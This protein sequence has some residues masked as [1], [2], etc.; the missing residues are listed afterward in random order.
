MLGN[1]YLVDFPH[2]GEGVPEEI[3]DR[4]IRLMGKEFTADM[5]ALRF[6]VVGCG[7]TGSPIAHLLARRGAGRILVVDRDRLDA[8]SCHRVHLTSV[9]DARTKAC[10]VAVIAREIR[11]IGLKTQVAMDLGS[12][13][14]GP[15]R[16]FNPSVK[17]RNVRYVLQECIAF[18]SS[19]HRNTRWVGSLT[20]EEAT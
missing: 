19:R 18:R 17:Y 1:R 12:L 5:R 16:R 2:R 20:F 8:S 14:P 4:Q 13:C 3:F 9:R 11:R 15:A 10:K 7:G 6:G